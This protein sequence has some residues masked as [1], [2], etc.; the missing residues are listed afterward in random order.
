MNINGTSFA[1]KPVMAVLSSPS[2]NGNVVSIVSFD[3]KS[4]LKDCVTR[5]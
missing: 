1:G 5:T 2:I 4:D 3:G